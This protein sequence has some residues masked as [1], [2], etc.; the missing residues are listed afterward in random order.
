MDDVSFCFLKTWRL[1]WLEGGFGFTGAPPVLLRE[2]VTQIQ[3]ATRQWLMFAG[4]TQQFVTVGRLW[5]GGRGVGGGGG[6]YLKKRN[7][8]TASLLQLILLHFLRVKPVGPDRKTLY[9]NGEML[10][11]GASVWPWCGPSTGG[12]KH[13]LLW[14]CGLQECSYTAIW[15][16]MNA[17]AFKLVTLQYFWILKSSNITLFA[18]IYLLN[19]WNTLCC[20]Y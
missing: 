3:F 13:R 16:Y 4:H 5:P 17:A 20:V 7:S 15:T 9:P 6:G 12:V 11:H 18:A 2:P 10:L 8:F 1:W 19:K 14:I